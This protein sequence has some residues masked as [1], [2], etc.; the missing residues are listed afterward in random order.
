MKKLNYLLLLLILP[1]SVFGQIT[2]TGTYGNPYTGTM[3]SGSFTISGTKYFNT[4]TVSG[5]TLTISAGATLFATMTTSFVKVTDSGILSAVG[6]NSSLITFSADNN[7]NGSHDGG[8]TWK[9]I[10]F[11]GPLGNSSTIE[12]AI[13]EY[14]TGDD[15]SVGGGI[16]I[17]YGN[18][19][20]RN[21]TI[22]NCVISSAASEGGGIYV[23]SGG[24]NITLQNLILHN[25]SAELHGG[26]LCL[27]GSNITV[28]NC[29][30]YSNSSGEGDGVYLN[31]ACTIST[32][33]IYNHTSGEGV[34][35]IN[36]NGALSN[37]LVYGNTTGIYFTGAGNIV[38]C[39]VINNSTGVTSASFNAPKLVNSVLWG[40]T[41]AQYS[42]NTGNSL[43]L[44]YCGIQGGLSGGTDGGHNATLSATNGDDTGPNFINPAIPDLHINAVITPLVDGGTASYSGVT[45]PTSDRES[46]SRLSTT[47]I[48][49]YEF[50]YYVWTGATSTD[51][52]ES[53]NWNGSFV[54]ALTISENQVIIPRGCDYYPVISSITLSSRSRLTIE[55]QA[56]VTVTGATTVDNG[57]TFLI[58]SDA[59]G[60]ANFITGS[61]VSG[62]FTI[63]MYLAGGGS[64]NYKWHYVSTP[65]NGIGTAVL[66][67]NIGNT[68]N[69]IKYNELIVTTDRNAG[70][71]WHDGHYGTTGFAVLNN[72][73]GYNVYTGTDQTAVF[74]GTIL[75]SQDFGWTNTMLTFSYPANPAQSGWNLIGNPFTSGV[76]AQSFVI[77]DNINK[78]IYYTKDNA[79]PTWNITT[80]EG[81]NGG[82]N[83]LPPLQGFFVHANSNARGRT[84]TIPAS[85]R[86][87]STAPLYKGEKGNPE[88]PILKFNV[89]D[90]SAFT[91]EALIY[92]FKDATTEFDGDY[93]AFKIINPN[94]VLP[95]IYTISN[96]IKLAMNGLPYP[97]SKT[98]VPLKIRIGESKNY[99]INV[100][101]LKNLND[102]NV[103]LTHGDKKIDLK[104]NPAYTF[105]ATAGTINDMSIIFEN[106]STDISIPFEEQTACW[107]SKGAVMIKPGLTGF[108]DNS[109]VMVSDI[110]GR[111]AYNI[112]NVSMVRGEI[113]ELP[114][115]LNKGIYL[116]TVSNNGLRI[117]KK[118]VITY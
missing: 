109:S 78:T 82:S 114:V 71:Q 68:Y 75:N 40:N 14:G 10:L 70:W 57:C 54:P 2:G 101:E 18:V 8:E 92:F 67:S 95:Q 13:I 17:F 61:S 80:N 118:I 90:G 69:L 1:V 64:P 115:N 96:D 66:T 46:H 35:I 110:N 3:S 28:S 100:L 79:Y 33:L 29:E 39:D 93:D 23:E 81:T 63:Q 24:Y 49:A 44:A 72:T 19:T 4:I 89:S 59:T 76:D 106:I 98:I 105:N 31:S 86:I 77:G 102:Y 83:L 9:N 51:W 87:I 52:S 56:A 97:E 15:Y 116:I 47:D 21:S 62:S 25:N 94:P 111:V 103:T 22:S 113:F 117:T 38:N 41:T 34:Y 20:V 43:E 5:G 107:Y 7:G 26:G 36:P 45:V 53:G 112:N 12:Y 48:G 104:G 37:C 27:T 74:S 91:D 88:Y 16:D 108:E 58:Q 30:I 55:P 6:A 50:F 32:S 85:S 84:L 42:I 60:S 11:D 73:T 65:V 99:T